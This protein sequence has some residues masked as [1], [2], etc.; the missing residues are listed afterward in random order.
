[1][2]IRDI[3]QELN[4]AGLL[5]RAWSGIKNIGTGIQASRQQRSS[6]EFI[7]GISDRVFGTWNQYIR[8]LQP[9]TNPN[10]ALVNFVNAQFHDVKGTKIPPPQ[11]TNTGEMS[12]SK[13]Y[14]LQR[15]QEYVNQRMTPQPT[16]AQ[17]QSQL[18]TGFANPKVQ[19]DVEI[20][21][22]EYG[23][24][25][26][27]PEG[28][29]WHSNETG[30]KITNAANVQTLNKRYYELKRLAA[31]GQVKD[32]DQIET[33]PNEP[34]QAELE[35][36]PNVTQFPRKPVKE[37]RRNLREGGNEIPD[38][39]A[40]AKN[41]VPGVVELAKKAMPGQLLKNVQLHIG[42]AGYK[43][44]SGDIDIMVEADDVVDFFGTGN[45]PDPVKAAKVMLKKHFESQGVV[46]SV[47]GRNVS[48]GI[49]YKQ[50]TTGQSRRAQ[51]DV[52]VIKEASLV[53]PWHQHG[54]R[55]M[56]DDPN[57]KASEL[58]ILLS[59][60]AKH[61]NLKIDPFAAKLINR[62]TG[63]VVGRTRKEVAK[64]LLNPRA[65]ESDLNSVGS[66]LKALEFDADIDGKLAQARQDSAKG[67]L[68]LPESAP[69]NTA[70]YYR[71]ISD[72]VE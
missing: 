23:F 66:V 37:S 17:P 4:E 5:R 58:F 61:L 25:L 46:A 2:K 21:G 11:L 36:G 41:D 68:R 51:V 27:G 18:Q 9:G 19:A 50:S 15:T 60:I 20:N 10:Q 6:D 38:A 1:M 62:D 22:H 63:E 31:A 70:A 52:M 7:K 34:K 47:N 28:P 16:A 44:E 56:Y 64:I 39:S 42:S 54:L 45:L 48:I 29:A 35:L 32:P 14:I 3:T 13:N 49:D 33:D 55:G 30:Q 65:K 40:V 24:D 67:L 8:T 72:V 53:A 12:K 71:K 26:Y 69:F 43:V 57:F 59:S